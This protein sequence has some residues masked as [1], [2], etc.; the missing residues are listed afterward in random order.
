M[1]D[2]DFTFAICHGQSMG[3][4]N[5][6]KKPKIQEVID[7]IRTQSI[8]NYEILILGDSSKVNM[9][10]E[11]D[12]IRCLDFDDSQMSGKWLTKKKNILTK[13]AKYENIVYMHNYVCLNE[14]WYP[15]FLKFGEDFRICTTN[16]YNMD[17]S[18][19][20]TWILN[21]FFEEH[22]KSLLGNINKRNE[23][24]LPD[25]ATKY[26]KI[27]YIPGYYWIAKKSVMLDVP[28]DER[29]MQ[30]EAEDCEW[31]LRASIKYNFSLNTH[32]S[33]F[34][35]RPGKN[36]RRTRQVLGE[37]VMS[38]LDNLSEEQINE[39]HSSER[40]TYRSMWL[41]DKKFLDEME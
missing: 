16:A 26:S 13:E 36:D 22:R 4:S 40:E 12:D 29:I 39:Y 18:K 20:N 21:P 7:S 5:P 25:D 34:L 3:A 8:K 23:Y 15:G 35:L 31:S 9:S 6:N 14:D 33:V 37:D 2:I 17:N 28:L 32:S 30:A 38:H 10:F 41:K 19:N 11:G 1:S 27:Q 24:V